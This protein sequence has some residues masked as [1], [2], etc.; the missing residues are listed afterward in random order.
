MREQFNH[1]GPRVAGLAVKLAEACGMSREDIG[2]I[3]AGAAL[4]DIG[5]IFTDPKI[6]NKDGPLDTAERAKI[7]EHVAMGWAIVEQA[8]YE[9]VILDIVRSH[10]EKWDGT[11]YP[12]G[13]I[14][15]EIP[16]VARLVCVCDVYQAL[17]AKRVYR[18]P[19]THAFSR[20]YMEAGR[21]K[22]F[23]PELLDLFFEKVVE[24]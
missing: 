5:K 13:L 4:H 16:F 22:T 24:G 21:G 19:H 8:G 7:Q 6:L 23:D 17:T 20:T 15:K 10:H 14:G 2:L 9:K 1:H 11:G 12:D 18:E 3:A